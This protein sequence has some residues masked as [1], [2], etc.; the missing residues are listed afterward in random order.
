MQRCGVSATDA[1]RDTGKQERVAG[2]GRTMGTLTVGPLAGSP[3][4]RGREP[5][6]TEPGLPLS[7]GT[8]AGWLRSCGSDLISSSSSTALVS[9]RSSLGPS[10][11]LAMDVKP[12]TDTSPRDDDT[13]KGKEKA[14][15]GYRAW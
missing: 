9:S 14:R 3:G 5:W 2:C 4:P 1:Y 15:R 13:P 6:C 10:A 11:S 12:P 7:R 8:W